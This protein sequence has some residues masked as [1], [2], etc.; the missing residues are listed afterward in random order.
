MF[1]VIWPHSRQTKEHAPGVLLLAYTA[2]HW[3]IL[4][5]Y[6]ISPRPKDDPPTGSCRLRRPRVWIEVA[7]RGRRERAYGERQFETGVSKLNR[8]G[9]SI[10]R[11][12]GGSGAGV[13]ET[14]VGALGRREKKE[15]SE[16]V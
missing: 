11:I 4:S 13:Q 7:K 9:S 10:V 12:Y 5:L 8:K 2:V 16:A 6:H 3:Y 15:L 14:C 1:P